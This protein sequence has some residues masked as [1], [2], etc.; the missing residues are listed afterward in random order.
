MSIKATAGG[1]CWTDLILQVGRK[2]KPSQGDAHAFVFLLRKGYRASLSMG[3]AFGQERGRG[4]P[5]TSQR[6]RIGCEGWTQGRHSLTLR[7]NHH[8]VLGSHGESNLIP[9][10]WH[11][12]RHKA[13][14]V[15]AAE[16]LRRASG[17]MREGCQGWMGHTVLLFAP[18][19]WF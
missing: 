18:G 8:K 6:C 2:G 5:D 16:S 1:Q 14:P 15:R 4:K 13:Q 7:Q 12:A 19:C 17:P 11:L 10:Q 3:L 9:S